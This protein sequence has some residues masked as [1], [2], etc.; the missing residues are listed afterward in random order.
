MVSVYCKINPYK[1]RL[2][3]LLH[4]FF[5]EKILFQKLVN[6][7][8]VIVSEIIKEVDKILSI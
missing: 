2:E 1:L 6:N 3:F 7:L 4:I 5:L 8:S